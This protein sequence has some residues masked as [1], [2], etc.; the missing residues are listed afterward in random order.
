M[1]RFQMRAA[2]ALAGLLGLAGLV[3]A[4]TTGVAC[5]NDY[6]IVTAS[7]LGGISGSTSCTTLALTGG[8]PAV[9]EIQGQST[10]L[11]ALV[12]VRPIP[13]APGTVCLPPSTCPIPFTACSAFTNLS[14]DLT[15]P[16][17]TPTFICPMVP[18]PGTPCSECQINV[19]LPPN[20]NFSTQAVILDPVCGTTPFI[21]LPT[22]AYTV[23]T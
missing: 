2:L 19:V 16:V 11:L 3:G 20:I 12:L 21:L 17:P 15:L 23:S 10:G 7:G 5:L 4:Q 22:Q 13:C 14:Y 8:G 18:I 6:T 9:V 1:S